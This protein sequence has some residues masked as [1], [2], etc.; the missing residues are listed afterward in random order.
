MD[1]DASIFQGNAPQ[2][3]PTCVYVCTNH[4]TPDCFVN[5]MSLERSSSVLT[6]YVHYRSILIVQRRAFSAFGFPYVRLN[7]G[8]LALSHVASNANAMQRDWRRGGNMQLIC[9]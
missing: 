1:E 5:I 8:S 2:N 4:F 6:V 7:T 9:I 3:L